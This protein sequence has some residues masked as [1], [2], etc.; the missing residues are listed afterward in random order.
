MR[1]YLD[2]AGS[3]LPSF[4]ISC[5]EFVATFAGRRRRVRNPFEQTRQAAF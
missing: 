1:V 4:V 3:G 5:N 2:K